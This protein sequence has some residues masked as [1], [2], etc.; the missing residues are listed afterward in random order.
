[1]ILP[2]DFL[3]NRFWCANGFA[4][5]VVAVKGGVGDWAAYI[6]GFSDESEEEAIRFT[7]LRGTKMEAQDAIDLFRGRWFVKELLYRD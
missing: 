6:S 5:C 7:I 4:A 3:A 1:M 2:E